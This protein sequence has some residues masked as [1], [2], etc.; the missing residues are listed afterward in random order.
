LK[1]I[2]LWGF[3]Q[4]PAFCDSDS[5]G[6]KLKSL[7]DTSTVESLVSLQVTVYNITPD[8][9]QVFAAFNRLER[10]IIQSQDNHSRNNQQEPNQTTPSITVSNPLIP[11][12]L[13]LTSC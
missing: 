10:L 1:Q 3:D 5:L 4:R 7:A 6:K 11:G 12:D 9:L 2:N 8:L 13:D